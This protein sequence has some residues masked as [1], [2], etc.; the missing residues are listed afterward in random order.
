MKNTYDIYRRG[1]Y[2]LKINNRNIRTMCEI[3]SKLVKKTLEQ[4][5]ECR[6]GVFFVNFEQISHIVLVFLCIVD[7]EQVNVGWGTLK[8]A[9]IFLVA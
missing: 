9:I 6:S 5:Q 8:F 1:I 2:L 3:Y 7:F 4:G